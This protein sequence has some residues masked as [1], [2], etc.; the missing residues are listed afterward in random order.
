MAPSRCKIGG[1]ARLQVVSAQ[2]FV[3]PDVGASV[4]KRYPQTLL[5]V[6]DCGRASR[7]AR[8]DNH[9]VILFPC[10]RSHSISLMH[11]VIT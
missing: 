3:R 9:N 6:H 7:D 10:L 11:K 5:G 2:D 4:E 1:T 8:A